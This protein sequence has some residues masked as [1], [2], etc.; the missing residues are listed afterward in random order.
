VGTA[1]EADFADLPPAIG[2]TEPRGAARRNAR[3]RR[4]VTAF[5]LAV[6]DVACLVIALVT[7]HLLLFGAIPSQ[8]YI[9]GELLAAVIWLGV[10]AGSGLY[11]TVNLSGLEEARR[12]VGAVSLGTVAMIIG[13]FMFDPMLS[14]AW[15]ALTFGI[16]LLLEL[17]ARRFARWTSARKARSGAALRTLVVGHGEDALD[18]IESLEAGRS[19]FRTLGYV[20]ADDPVVDRAER[21]MAERIRRLRRLFQEYDP[22]CVFVASPA[23]GADK[24][25]AILQA[26][27]QEG[28]VV[29][30]Y[31][32]VREVMPSRLRVQSV[33]QAGIALTL[34]PARLSPAQRL[35]KRSM[36]LV[37][38]GF[39]LLIT[40]PVLLVV[41][42]LIKATSRGPVLFRQ[43][44]VTEAG[45][46]FR[47]YKFR[48]MRQDA[49]RLVAEQGVDTSVPFFKL[50]KDPRLTPLGKW[51]RK[52]SID[53]LP[54][55]VNVV[56]GHL[57]LVGP[58]PLPADQ[59]AANLEL[60]GPRH[61]VR[62]GLTGWWQIQGRSDLSPED[63]IRMDHFYIQNW[64]PILDLYIML[65]TV[66]TLTGRSGAY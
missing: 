50:K 66:R 56:L 5:T 63:A 27:R 48:T 65:R 37:L 32:Q 14:R 2:R 62:A 64:S 55:L 51:L 20:S 17:C 13:G 16:A 18:L 40:L 35:V 30:I 34:K 24:L 49:D 7:S 38:S 54:Q 25:T 33:G 15:I 21:P 41:S 59:V 36:D 19:G 58:R 23:I 1:P 47:M 8:G 31:T 42:V 28:L 22:D 43:D 45:R 9:V 12:T 29:R 6:A 3:H 57:S 11:D 46:T 53:E 60:L 26:A 10:F 44:R 4:R 52:L 61:E 39:A